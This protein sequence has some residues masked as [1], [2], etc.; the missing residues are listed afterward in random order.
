M[1][2]SYVYVR[3]STNLCVSGCMLDWGSQTQLVNWV[4]E[5][6]NSGTQGLGPKYNSKTYSVCSI[7][8]V[9]V[10]TNVLLFSTLFLILL[11]FT[12]VYVILIYGT[13][14]N[15]HQKW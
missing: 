8:H 14:Q 15:G 5:P 10:V 3:M 12:L 9:I 13:V 11:L 2:Q 4:W 6:W 7:L 1:M